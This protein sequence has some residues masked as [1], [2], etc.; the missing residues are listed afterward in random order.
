MLVCLHKVKSSYLHVTWP[1][2][3]GLGVAES[4]PE[5]TE[6]ETARKPRKPKTKESSVFHCRNS[7]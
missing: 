1:F 4:A 7:K 3:V 5:L 6:K 2:P